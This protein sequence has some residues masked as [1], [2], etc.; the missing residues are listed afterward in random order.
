[1]K[2]I[3]RP[4]GMAEEYAKLALNIY[5]GCTHGCTYCYGAR[6]KKD[7]YY[8]WASPKKNL[9]NKLREDVKELDPDTCPEILLSFQGDVYQPEDVNLGLTRQVIEILIEYHLPF[10]ILT[11][12]GV[13]AN[14]DFDLLK[15]SGK[16]KFG[17]SMVF[18]SE[19]FAEILEPG[20]ASIEN[21]MSAIKDAK[22][23]GIP[24]WVSVEPVIF[25]GEALSVIIQ[26]DEHVDHWKVGKINHDADLESSV[27]WLEF[28]SDVSK[29]LTR[30][31]T[32][33]YLKN[34]LTDL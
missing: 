5:N 30:L 28:R 11:K 14:R 32:S 16:A 31:G 25:P 10:S 6:Y 21:R 7:E 27:D 33:F 17:T 18:R 23:L 3:Y 13:R 15:E 2:V 20:A 1:M 9:I 12:G 4:A 19:G 24:T 34:S 26:M 22:A 29:L 8:R